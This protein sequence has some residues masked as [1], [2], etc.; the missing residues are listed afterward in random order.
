MGQGMHHNQEYNKQLSDKISGKHTRGKSF[1]GKS[2]L[3]EMASPREGNLQQNFKK[4]FNNESDQDSYESK[5]TAGQ[6]LLQSIRLDIHKYIYVCVLHTLYRHHCRILS[7][8]Y[9]TG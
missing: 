7:Y 9:S 8:Q 4:V 5:K 1:N 3:V 2:T 6:V